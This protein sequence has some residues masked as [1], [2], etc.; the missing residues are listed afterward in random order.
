MLSSWE[1]VWNLEVVQEKLSQGINLIL[2]I[3][4]RE[5]SNLLKIKHFP[6]E[7]IFLLPPSMQSLSELKSRGQTLK[8]IVIS[9]LKVPIAKYFIQKST[10]IF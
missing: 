8:I 2:E 6:V 9:G 10:V 7:S 3:D 5:L 1:H 4:V